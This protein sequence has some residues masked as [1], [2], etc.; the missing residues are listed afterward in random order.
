M[1]EQTGFAGAYGTLY[2]AGI[3]VIRKTNPL[4]FIAE[5]VSGFSSAD[6]GKTILRQIG[7]AVPVEGAQIIVEAILKTFAGVPYEAVDATYSVENTIPFREQALDL[8]S[9]EELKQTMFPRHR[10][11]VTFDDQSQMN[12]QVSTDGC[13]LSC[14]Y[15]GKK[16]TFPI[17]AVLEAAAL[18][19]KESFVSEKTLALHKP[20]FFKDSKFAAFAAIVLLEKAGFGKREQPYRKSSVW[21]LKSLE[22]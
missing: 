21:V 8:P 4:W 15:Q 12:I 9:D 20:A 11:R 13:R 6:N 2:Q 3:S 19:R 17:E 18:F 14:S 1:G 10:V 22:K 16:E 7:M 5:N